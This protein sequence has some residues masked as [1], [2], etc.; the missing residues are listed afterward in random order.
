[1]S[2]EMTDDP[3]LLIMVAFISVTADDYIKHAGYSMNTYDLVLSSM[4]IYYAFK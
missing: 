2:Y 3:H 1:M 4:L